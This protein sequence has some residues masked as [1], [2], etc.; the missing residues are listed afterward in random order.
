MDITLKNIKTYP[1][2]SKETLAFS[3]T[4]YVDG[5]KT[6]SVKNAGN[7][8]CNDYC[9]YPNSESRKQFEAAWEYAR[10]T[11]TDFDFEHLDVIINK[12]IIDHEYQQLCKK[13][14]VVRLKSNP[15]QDIIYPEMFSDDVVEFIRKRHGDDIE[16]IMNFRFLQ[17]INLQV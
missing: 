8:G 14:I 7:G 5:K 1:S 11:E 2:L 9:P 16:E 15:Y 3:A 12:L 13:N 6:A 10:K 4:M 17:P